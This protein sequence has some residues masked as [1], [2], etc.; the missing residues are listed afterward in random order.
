[1]QVLEQVDKGYL[2]IYSQNAEARVA[3][4]VLE[5][6]INHIVVHHCSF[7]NE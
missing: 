3:R 6:F 4:S 5:P 1:M 2:H 7:G